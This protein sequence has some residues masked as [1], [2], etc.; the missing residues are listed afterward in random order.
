MGIVGWILI[1]LCCEVFFVWM[2]CLGEGDWVLDWGFVGGR[3]G[4][5]IG[6]WWGEMT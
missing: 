2:E 1:G 3:D 6:R 4:V 5:E